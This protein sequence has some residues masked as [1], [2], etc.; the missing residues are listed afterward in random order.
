M[1]VQEM[2]AYTYVFQ[3]YREWKRDLWKKRVCLGCK[4]LASKQS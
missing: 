1:D 2:L 4:D 3:G